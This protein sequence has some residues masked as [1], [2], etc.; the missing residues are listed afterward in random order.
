VILRVFGVEEAPR[1]NVQ[2]EALGVRRDGED[3]PDVFGQTGVDPVDQEEVPVLEDVPE[4][5]LGLGL[6]LTVLAVVATWSA[7]SAR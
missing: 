3:G 1:R 2:L 5:D 4:G 7:N 6:E